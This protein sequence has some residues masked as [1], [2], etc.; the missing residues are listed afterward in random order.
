[1]PIALHC[2]SCQTGFLTS[3]KPAGTVVNC[4]QCGVRMQVPQVPPPV[5]LAVPQPPSLPAVNQTRRG[6]FRDIKPVRVRKHKPF[7]GSR[8]SATFTA[9]GVFSLILIVLGAGL[10]PL[11]DRPRTAKRINPI[12]PGGDRSL[13]FPSSGGPETSTTKYKH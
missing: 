4:P 7:G 3:N 8:T 11:L 13:P 6:P 1:M 9:V 2:P 12:V 5:P 10:L